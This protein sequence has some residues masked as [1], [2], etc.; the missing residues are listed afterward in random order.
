MFKTEVVTLVILA[1]IALL[2]STSFDE[3]YHH[4]LVVLYKSP[5]TRLLLIILTIGLYMWNN[6]IGIMASVI[7]IFYIADVGLMSEKPFIKS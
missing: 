7:I 2:Y 4:K 1:I 5:I 6:V 3:L